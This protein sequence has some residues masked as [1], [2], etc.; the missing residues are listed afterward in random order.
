MEGLRGGV[1]T[2]SRG[3]KAPSELAR[4]G[5]GRGVEVKVV[6]WRGFP[7][8]L[9]AAQ[10]VGGRLGLLGWCLVNARPQECG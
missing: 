10:C 9:G 8:R 4:V 6:E 3:E 7:G 1:S 2:S 5:S